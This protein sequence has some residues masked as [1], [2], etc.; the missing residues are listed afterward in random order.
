MRFLKDLIFTD[1]H[2]VKG[3]ANTGS[4][5]LST[6]LTNTRKRFLAMEESTRIRHDGGERIQSAQML[7][8]INDI[9]LAHEMEEAGDIGLRNI[10]LR[11]RAE[12][13]VTFQLRYDSPLQL[14]G[15]VRKRAVNSDASRIHDFIVVANPRLQGFPANPSPEYALLEKA[16]YLIVNKSRIEF[17]FL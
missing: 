13:A 16:S 9:L 12:I 11:D 8:C 15:V 1:S 7:V 14:S 17:I 3:H 2:L 6:F 10:A 5:R 4:Q